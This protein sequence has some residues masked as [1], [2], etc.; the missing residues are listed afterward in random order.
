MVDPSK[1]KSK[2]RRKRGSIVAEAK[3]RPGRQKCFWRISKTFYA[4]KT[5]SLCP[6]HMLRG[7]KTRKLSGNTSGNTEETLA[8]I[9][10]RLF[11]RLRSQRTYFEHVEFASR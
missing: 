9:V 7:D 11:S 3:L 1:S 4:S 8:L 2:G 10:S 5:Q 6:E